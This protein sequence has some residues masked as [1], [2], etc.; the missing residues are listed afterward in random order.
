MCKLLKA[1]GGWFQPDV[2][3]V[4]TKESPRVW[5]TY[6]RRPAWERKTVGRFLAAHEGNVIKGL[7]GLEGTPQFLSHPQPWTVEM[8]LLKAKNVSGKRGATPLPP[9]YFAR[10]WEMIAAMHA[11]GINH[12]DLRRKNLLRS[13]EDPTVPLAVDFTQSFHFPPPQGIFRAA[14]FRRA[15][16]IDRLKFLKLKAAF[17]GEDALTPQEQVE[18]LARPWY[19][20]FGQ[21]MRRRI[22]RPIRRRVKGRRKA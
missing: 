4:D 10:L 16:L 13:S 14:I 15:A 3:I 18:S 12:G 20:R 5:K 6:T 8:S 21:I 22:Y 19:L 11:R 9:I 7:A 17:L 2:W 1:S